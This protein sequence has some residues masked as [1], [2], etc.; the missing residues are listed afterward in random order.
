MS[1]L[2]PLD[3]ELLHVVLIYC[4]LPKVTHELWHVLEP[5][6]HWALGPNRCMA[7]LG[8]V[9]RACT[10][11]KLPAEKAGGSCWEVWQEGLSWLFDKER[12]YGVS[13]LESLPMLCA[14]DCKNYPC[15]L[16]GILRTN[17]IACINKLP[18]IGEVQALRKS[19][20]KI[21]EEAAALHKGSFYYPSFTAFFIISIRIAD[22]CSLALTKSLSRCHVILPMSLPMCR[23]IHLDP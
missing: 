19:V 12:A 17:C 22:R 23:P 14:W 21:L 13:K 3:G 5:L 9:K 2:H 16:G 6:Q 20:L 15:I 10:K 4:S 7:I 18:H 8:F 1:T 11:E